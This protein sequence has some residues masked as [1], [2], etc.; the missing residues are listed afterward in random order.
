MIKL[1]IYC[2]SVDVVGNILQDLLGKHLNIPDFEPEANFPTITKSCTVLMQQIQWLQSIQAQ[3][4]SS[5]ADQWN[6]LKMVVLLAEDSRAL[7]Q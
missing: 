3:I 1:C 2:D 6:G 4:S 5:I 7:D